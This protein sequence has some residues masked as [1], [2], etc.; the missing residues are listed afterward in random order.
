MKHQAQVKYFLML[1]LLSLVLGISVASAQDLH[2]H[3]ILV[4]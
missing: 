1:V 3:Q 2:R 4:A